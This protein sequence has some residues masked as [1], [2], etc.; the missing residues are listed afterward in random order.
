MSYRWWKCTNTLWA[1]VFLLLSGC[2]N[3]GGTV[4]SGMTYEVMKEQGA[5]KLVYVVPLS[6]KS[7]VPY[8]EVANKVCAGERI[9]IAL[10]WDEKENVPLSM[11]MTDMQVA[12]KVAHYNLNKNTGL[13]RVRICSNEGCS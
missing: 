1:L 13:D 3:E 7:K 2:F 9:C 10:F 8:R 11:P 4:R 6:T 5:F 12:T